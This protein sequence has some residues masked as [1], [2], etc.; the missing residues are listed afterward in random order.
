MIVDNNSFMSSHRDF[1]MQAVE[2]AEATYDIVSAKKPIFVRWVADPT[3]EN[4]A[5][6]SPRLATAA[7]TRRSISAPD[8]ARWCRG[9]PA[10]RRRTGARGR[11]RPVAP[12]RAETKIG[13][14]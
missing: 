8:E 3:A 4:D 14:N 2:V 13:E 5:N 1:Y 11:G 6:S 9:R 10:S 7:S 12:K